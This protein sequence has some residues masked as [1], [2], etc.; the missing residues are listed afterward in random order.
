[1]NRARRNSTR[2]SII[3][4]SFVG[5][6]DRAVDEWLTAAVNMGIPVIAAA[7]NNAD[8][9]CMYSPAGNEL[10]YTV[11]ASN[12]QD[13][14]ASYSNTGKCVNLISPGSEIMS[15]WPNEGRMT[16]SGTSQ[17]V[18]HVSG[19]AALLL[20]QQPELTPL[21]LYALLSSTATSNALKVPTNTV[22]K[23]VYNRI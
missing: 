12:Q 11:G 18:P 19:S 8:D 16:L 9:S 2:R 17:A 20:S 15:T 22:N 13:S 3:N 7:G 10:V 1:M 6:K 4:I 21:E 5:P 14:L 23:L